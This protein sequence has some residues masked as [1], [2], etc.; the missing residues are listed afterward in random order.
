MSAQD[1]A[2]V[3]IVMFAVCFLAKLDG[4]PIQK[5][6]VSEIQLMHSLGKHLTVM[7]RVEW[8]LKKMQDVRNFVGL[9]APLLTKEGGFQ[10]PRK[11]EDNILV[12]SHHKS[13]GEADKAD[14]DVLAKVKSQ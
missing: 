12:V 4:K 3:M 2:K 1:M 10:K 14:V 7:D 13:L 5:R 9:K 8:L 6:A 11:K